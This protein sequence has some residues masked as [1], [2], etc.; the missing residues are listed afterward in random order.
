MLK[1]TCSVQKR[2]EACPGV[3]LKGGIPSNVDSPKSTSS[4]LC[5][6]RVKVWHK[7]E[8]KHI[9]NVLDRFIAHARQVPTPLSREVPLAIDTCGME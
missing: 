3:N 6:I 1:A 7:C 2:S 5:L 4:L 8:T 9:G